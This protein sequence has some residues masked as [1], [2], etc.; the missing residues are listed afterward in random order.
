[1]SVGMGEGGRKMGVEEEVREKGGERV[2][3]SE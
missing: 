3:E 2:E 1:M